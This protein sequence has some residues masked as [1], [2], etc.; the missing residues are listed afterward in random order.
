MPKYHYRGGSSLIGLAQACRRGEGVKPYK[1]GSVLWGVASGV[2][3]RPSTG[4]PKCLD[5][6]AGAPKCWGA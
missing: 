5:A 4:T 1:A 2:L 6:L 3:R